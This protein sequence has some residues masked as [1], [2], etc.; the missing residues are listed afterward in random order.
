MR[1]LT[2]KGCLEQNILSI[3]ERLYVK[4]QNK[5]LFFQKS[6]LNRRTKGINQKYTNMIPLF[7]KYSNRRILFLLAGL[8]LHFLDT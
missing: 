5:H 1:N 2:R 7:V 6:L 8:G 3:Q 4:G